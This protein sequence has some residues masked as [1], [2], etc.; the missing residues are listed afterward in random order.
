[1]VSFTLWP[2]HLIKNIVQS[3]KKVNIKYVTLKPP[4]PHTHIHENTRATS[5]TTNITSEAF[6][7][8][9]G[10]KIQETMAWESST[11]LTYISHLSHMYSS[12]LSP[13]FTTITIPGYPC[14]IT[15]FLLYDTLNFPLPSSLSDSR[16]FLCNIFKHL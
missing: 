15:K 6:R 9:L 10:V 12:L 11:Y 3:K 5:S 1:V 4:P 7:S 16:I 2:L 14:Q 13:R 8:L